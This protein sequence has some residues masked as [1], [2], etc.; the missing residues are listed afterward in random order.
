[1]KKLEVFYFTFNVDAVYNGE[2]LKD[3]YFKIEAFDS[4][5]A[6]YRIRQMFRDDWHKIYTACEFIEVGR[7]HEVMV[8]FKLGVGNE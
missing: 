8:E 5:M 4:D 2:P 7:K 3:M 1:M 6:C